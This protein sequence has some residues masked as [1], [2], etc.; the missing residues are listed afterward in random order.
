MKKLLG[1]VVTFIS[2]V[3]ILWCMVCYGE[4]VCKN[5]SPNPDYADNNIIVNFVEWANERY[6]Y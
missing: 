1:N 4:I 6:G 2:V 5:T 3:F